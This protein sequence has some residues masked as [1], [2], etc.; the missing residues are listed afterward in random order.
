MAACFAALP[1]LP[2]A[3]V[4]LRIFCFVITHCLI[5]RSETEPLRKSAKA[6]QI[7][8]FQ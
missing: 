1:D 8:P 4:Y 5:R 3:R 7:V 6:C 2:R